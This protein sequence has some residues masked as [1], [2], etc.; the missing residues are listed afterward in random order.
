MADAIGVDKTVENLKESIRKKDLRPE[1]FSIRTLFETL[2]TDKRTGKACGAEVL[3][4]IRKGTIQENLANFVS[5]SAFSSI[6]GQIF[7]NAIL[8]A[9]QL[10]DF[11]VSPMFGV[12]QSNIITQSEKVAGISNIGD[13]SKVVGEGQEIPMASVSEDFVNTPQQQK[14]GLRVP[15]TREALMSDR[16][17]VLL[18][19]CRQVGL[20]IGIAREKEA[21]DTIIAADGAT[22]RVA[23]NWRG[24]AYAPWQTSATNAPYYDNTTASNALLNHT[25]INNAYLTLAAIVD[26]LTGE[27]LADQGKYTLLVT[28]ENAFVAQRIK[29]ALQFR[30]GGAT[31][32]DFNPTM[33]A[34]GKCV[35]DFD[36]V[37]SKYLAS[38]L[39]NASQAT[40]HW[41]FGDFARAYKWMRSLDIV[42]EEAMPNSGLMF[43]HDI[44]TQYRVLKFESASIHQP[45]VVT[46]NTVA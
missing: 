17:G 33:V 29:A 46:K 4:E 36:I 27:P 5:A 44:M 12:I 22:G 42:V 41:Y 43:S 35:V 23:Y 28:P 7:Y 18:E 2:V 20:A 14:M 40:S 24:T 19:R 39:T 26:P 21:V 9:Y 6:T 15:I 13:A 37:V 3:E 45:R 1:D 25:S 34:D 8:D 16:T 32:T 31:P 10:A 30:T 38:R 11:N